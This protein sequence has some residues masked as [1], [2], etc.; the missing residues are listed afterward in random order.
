[1]TEQNLEV[2][3][4]EA[5]SALKARDYARA[6]ELLKQILLE[7]HD[8]KDVSRLLATTV[9]LRRRRWYNHPALW[10]VI[11]AAVVIGL[12]F[13]VAPRLRGIS[14]KPDPTSTT[15]PT[16]TNAPT[17]NLDSTD[18]P[19][20]TET[21][22]PIPT[23]LPLAWKRVS[24]GQDFRRD[25]VNAI[26]VNPKD[27]DV[28]YAGLANSG[29]YKSIDGGLSWQPSHRGLDSTEVNSLIIDPTTPDRLYAGTSSGTYQTNDGGLFWDKV[30][31][32]ALQLWI[33]PD[34]PTHVIG[35][36]WNTIFE[37]RD[38]GKTWADLLES[39]CPQNPGGFAIDPDNTQRILLSER[40]G[41][42]CMTGLYESLD[43][44]K[45]F[46]FL[47]LKDNSNISLIAISSEINGSKTIYVMTGFN[48]LSV[49]RDD[50]RTWSRA[51]LNCTD[52]AIDPVNPGTVYCSG[53]PNGVYR[54]RDSG[55]NWDVLDLSL[56]SVGTL[57]VDQYENKTRLLAG[58][59]GFSRSMD[60]GVSW[61]DLSN[62]LG[63]LPISLAL[64]PTKKEAFYLGVNGLNNVFLCWLYHSG[65]GG[66]T[67]QELLRAENSWCG[68]TVG[69]ENDLYIID[70]YWLIRSADDGVTWRGTPF[71]PPSLDSIAANPYIPGLIY[72]GAGN[73]EPYLYYS[74][75]YGGSWQPVSGMNTQIWNPRLF[76][77]PGGQ[78][79][80]AINAGENF[81]RSNDSGINWN[82]CPSP[83]EPSLSD[84]GLVI[85]VRDPDR[86]LLA[87]A[88]DGVYYSSNGCRTWDQV[89]EGLSNLFVST[90]ALDPNNPDTVYA[91]T[92]G[93]AYVSF[94]FGQT[95]NQINDGLLGAT[96]VYSIVV[97]KDSNVYAATPY[98]IFK[99]ENK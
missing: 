61:S 25:I 22:V 91:G 69:A 49:S 90:L 3:Y 42:D 19:S 89:N 18:I 51:S 9:K 79:V 97:D 11:G 64:D 56:V 92:D 83:G 16:G 72:A 30:G 59:Y 14:A 60:N 15:S 54:T 12:G 98:G 50:G 71:Q 48:R 86:L 63:T 46:Q 33:D 32:E 31:P 36:W 6:S 35:G 38:A 8:Y 87:T 75:N 2:L 95:W 68:P 58:G 88:R 26:A 10:S 1:M 55:K 24:L 17:A 13:A 70:H 85:D 40:D 34:D 5:Q 84:S 82:P 94:D 20:P 57:H 52:F 28:I 47:A 96:V 23:P 4:R 93:G 65:D 78:T 29:I 43:G 74:T 37:T 7:D 73:G 99:L 53:S 39:D 66:R 67:W 45:T 76:F 62:G 21:L 44:G 27:P 41:D 80:Y 77:A 81:Y